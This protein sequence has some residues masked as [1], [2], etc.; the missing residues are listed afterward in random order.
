MMSE[1]KF[2]MAQKLHNVQ[3][4]LMAKSIDFLKF[5]ELLSIIFE[6]CSKENLTFWFNFH[7]DYCVLNLRDIGHENY[8]LNIRKAYVGV[9]ITDES[10]IENKIQLLQNAFLLTEE[11]IVG[12]L[13]KTIAEPTIKSSDDEKDSV[14][15][16]IFTSDKPIPSHVSN[17]IE[18]IKAKGIPVNRESLKNH[19]PWDKI[20][21]EQRIK[22]TEYLNEMGASK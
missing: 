16:L 10:L 3:E 22:C 5:E 11:S 6:E 21:T 8:E 15:D 7:E 13:A 20:S 18:K 4:N 9:P 2:V 1:S 14:D 17:A 12:S 19:I